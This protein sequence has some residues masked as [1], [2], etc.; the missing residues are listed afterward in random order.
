VSVAASLFVR[1]D[2]CCR[3]MP[4]PSL[5]LHRITRA[6]IGHRV[7]VRAPSAVTTVGAFRCATDSGR[8]RSVLAMGWADRLRLTRPF[9]LPSAMARTVRWAEPAPHGLGLKPRPGTLPVGNLFSIS[10]NS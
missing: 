6:T 1:R 3:I 2:S 8:P 7:A 5:P 9:G 10:F 4:V